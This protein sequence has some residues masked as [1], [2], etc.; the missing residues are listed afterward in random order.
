LELINKYILKNEFLEIGQFPQKNLNA[1]DWLISVAKQQVLWL[2]STFH[3]PWKTVIP[4]HDL[5][6]YLLA[7]FKHGHM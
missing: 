7:Y 1:A 6:T 2:G 3:G 5:V 4:S